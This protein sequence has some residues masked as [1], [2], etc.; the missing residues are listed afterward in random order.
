M[1]IDKKEEIASFKL[2]GPC[3]DCP[4]RKDLPEDYQ[5]WLGEQRAQGIAFD[6]FRMGHSFPCHKTT[7]LGAEDY[8]DYDEFGEE[9]S[10]YIY[11]EQTSQC[12]GAAIMQIKTGNTSAYM[13]IAER[14]GFTKEVEAIKNLDLD[15]P[16]FDSIEDFIKFHE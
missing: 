2:K 12:A 11:D 6:T 15:S 5:G 8:D 10:E 1:C 13:Q 7:N 9:K 4:F 14:L 3:K 16:V